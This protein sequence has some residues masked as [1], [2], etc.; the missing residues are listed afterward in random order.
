MPYEARAVAISVTLGQNVP[1]T[2]LAE[3]WLRKES[4]AVSEQAR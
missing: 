4:V 1:R 2:P 3:R